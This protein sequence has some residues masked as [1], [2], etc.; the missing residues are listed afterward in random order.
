MN[1]LPLS[2]GA[3]VIALCCLWIY[4][5]SRMAANRRGGLPYPPGPAGLPVL[6]N[7]FDMPS[8]HEWE[9]AVEWRSKYG[10]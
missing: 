5:R 8:S 1:A 6:G 7:A 10:V 9:K 2:V 4:I 3:P